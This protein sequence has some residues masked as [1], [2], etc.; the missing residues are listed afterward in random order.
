M[1]LETGTATGQLVIIITL[2]RSNF[3]LL[4]SHHGIKIGKK[5]KKK[6]QRRESIP[7][8]YQTFT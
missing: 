1:N 5:L 2:N 3:T 7:T 8:K 6:K 4:K